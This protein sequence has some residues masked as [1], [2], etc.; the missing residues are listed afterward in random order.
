M[1]SFPEIIQIFLTVNQKRED[2]H[3]INLAGISGGLSGRRG[4]D[5]EDQ[6]KE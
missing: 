3:L 1:D 2:C 5:N 4:G 6:G